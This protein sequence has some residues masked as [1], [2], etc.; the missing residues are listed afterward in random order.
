[1]LERLA[2]WYLAKRGITVLPRDFV[3]MA[4]G[5][6]TA[7]QQH[8][9]LWQVCAITSDADFKIIALNHTVVDYPP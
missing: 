8:P 2:M 7:V 1:M 4:L 3:G 9:N 5:M 6:A